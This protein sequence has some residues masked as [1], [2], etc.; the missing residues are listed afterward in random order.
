M[1]MRVRDFGVEHAADF[2]ATSLGTQLFTRI[3]SIVDELDTHG[4]SQVSSTGTA[5][6]GTV[7]RSQA[8][9]A[10]RD[11][12]ETINRTA[13][14]MAVELPGL[15]DK[16]RVPRE[17]NDQILLTAARAF[18]TD[19]APYVQNFVA[20]ELPA[21]FVDDLNED[22]EELE[23]AMGKQ[24]TGLGHRAAAIA[25]IDDT[26]DDGVT[27]V[28]K[29]DAIVKNKYIND[30]AVLAQW[31]SAS[32]TERSPRHSAPQTPPAQPPAPPTP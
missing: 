25:A 2:S 21:G 27:T 1:F 17:G 24:A 19:V 13:R 9:Q 12:L 31:T 3:G 14:A 6:Q 11:D 29:L 5:K 26:I 8:R 23:G 7:S 32:H 10:L 30:S 15:N 4:A 28:K 20:H 22:I 18:A 16:F